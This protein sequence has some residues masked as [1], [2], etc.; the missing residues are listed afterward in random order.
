ML[1]QV[2][3]QLCC[4]N[5][6]YKIKFRSNFFHSSRHQW[7]FVGFFFNHPFCFFRKSR[8]CPFL[9]ALNNGRNCWLYAFTV[10]SFRTEEKC[11]LYKAAAAHDKPADSPQWHQRQTGIITFQTS[12]NTP[13]SHG[14]LLLVGVCVLWLCIFFL[15]TCKELENIFANFFFAQFEHTG[16]KRSLPAPNTH[17]HY[18]QSPQQA[19]NAYA[20]ISMPLKNFFIEI[21]IAF[22]CWSNHQHLTKRRKGRQLINKATWQQQLQK[23]T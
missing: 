17:W 13:G 18:P 2:R 20:N 4:N 15:F 1:P 8:C 22:P 11:S 3:R 19:L 21:I 5:I 10:L 23:K 12:T 6:Y 14:I 7:D 16:I 9:T